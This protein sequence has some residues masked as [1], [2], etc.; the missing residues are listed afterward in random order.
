MPY[1]I[2]GH[3]LIP[4]IPGLSLTDVDD[5]LQLIELLQEFCRRARKNVEVFFD[6]S[7]PG[8]LRVRTFGPVTARFI[9][10]GATADQAIQARLRKLARAARNWTVVSSDLAV[11]A[12]ARAA[13][14]RPLSSEDFA[15]LLRQPS[16]KAQADAVENRQIDLSPDDVEEWLRLFGGDQDRR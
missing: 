5:E 16:G 14:A 9:R 8:G 15:R 1:L 4:H 7:P 2:D 13:Q 12:A 11:Q 10:Q 6:N 3:N